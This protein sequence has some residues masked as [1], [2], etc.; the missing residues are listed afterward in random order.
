MLYQTNFKKSVYYGAYLIDMSIFIFSSFYPMGILDFLSQRSDKQIQERA[1][2]CIHS[3]MSEY[4]MPNSPQLFA[5]FLA[6]Y[7]YN[8]NF[9][10]IKY[11]I[12][13]MATGIV[14]DE[15]EV[16]IGWFVK[17]YDSPGGGLTVEDFILKIDKQIKRAIDNPQDSIVIL[18]NLLSEVVKAWSINPSS[19]NVLNAEMEVR[20]FV[21]DLAK[22]CR[23][24]YKKAK[25][26]ILSEMTVKKAYEMQSEAIY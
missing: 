15:P 14:D 16:N 22:D 25:D 13:K 12:D 21:K 7:I 10:G 2:S 6:V 4:D 17:I 11:N 9:I 8:L 26:E 3:A 24:D 19:K 20:I 23:R 1:E 5:A 18:R